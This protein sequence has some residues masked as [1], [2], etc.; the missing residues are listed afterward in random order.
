MLGVLQNIIFAA[1]NGVIRT[2]K[3]ESCIVGKGKQKDME[4][5]DGENKK[6]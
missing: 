6:K 5:C 3:I 1:G 4:K 2:K